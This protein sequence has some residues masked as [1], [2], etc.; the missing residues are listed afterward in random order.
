M[1]GPSLA[2]CGAGSSSY[3]SLL[4]QPAGLELLNQTMGKLSL[5]CPGVVHGAGWEGDVNQQNLSD[6]R[7]DFVD[8]WPGQDYCVTIR[9]RVFLATW[10]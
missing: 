7:Q 2:A 9:Y 5:M 10:T 3:L 6:M 8:F 4:G 1:L